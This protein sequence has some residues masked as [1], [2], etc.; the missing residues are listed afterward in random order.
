MASEGPRGSDCQEY[1]IPWDYKRY[2]FS[3]LTQS[4]I[5]EVPR[6]LRNIKCTHTVDRK[7]SHRTRTAT[8]GR[9]PRYNDGWGDDIVRLPEWG[10]RA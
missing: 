8:K 5:V 7:V 10:C 3:E 4:R 2:S 1:K 6:E 9:R